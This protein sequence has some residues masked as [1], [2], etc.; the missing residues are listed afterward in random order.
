ML[1]G[2]WSQESHCT[3]Q[4]LAS[5]SGSWVSSSP[6][7]REQGGQRGGR[8]WR[9]EGA[10]TAPARALGHPGTPSSSRRWD[11][12][13]GK[14]PQHGRGSPGSTRLSRPCSHPITF[15]PL[16]LSLGFNGR[17]GFC[18]PSP[19][20]CHISAP[21]LHLT[22]A[23]RLGTQQALRVFLH[24]ASSP[25]PPQHDFT[26]CHTARKALRVPQH[27]PLPLAAPSVLT[28]T[29]EARQTSVDQL[30]IVR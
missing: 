12:C 5:S 27:P 17:S 29:D 19:A 30:V 1:S 15:S 4:H 6:A 22:P 25:S 20:C 23:P 24:R 9:A 26:A 18:F 14:G 3:S 7:G 28:R 8:G 16:T 2:G 11:W 13:A 10:S 21:R